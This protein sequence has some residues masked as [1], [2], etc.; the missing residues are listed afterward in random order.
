ME[1]SKKKKVKK[2]SLAQIEPPPPPSPPIATHEDEIK[3]TKK[4]KKTKKVAESSLAND[5]SPFPPISE[6]MSPSS[7]EPD[8][9][10]QA[11]KAAK[12]E[13]GKKPSLDKA[14]QPDPPPVYENKDEWEDEEETEPEK[15]LIFYEPSDSRRTKTKARPIRTRRYFSRVFFPD[16]SDKRKWRPYHELLP[17]SKSQLL[18]LITRGMT[19][20]RR[21]RLET[22]HSPFSDTYTH[23][24]MDSEEEEGSNSEYAPSTASDEEI[25]LPTHLLPF[26]PYIEKCP[27]DVTQEPPLI[28]VQKTWIDVNTIINWLQLCETQHG[29]PCIQERRTCPDNSWPGPILLIDVR[30]ECLMRPMPWEEYVALSYV[31]GQTESGRTTTENLDSLLQLGSLQG[32]KGIIPKAVQEAMELVRMLGKRYLWVDR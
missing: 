28:K 25:G 17:K 30:E 7:W 11:K 12:R 21:E 18:T 5:V 29:Y 4:S 31:W 14:K 27:E 2:S 15:P 24:S 6:L 20:Y 23:D 10:S 1:S 13:K 9:F 3:S 8:Y 22:V 26:V 16:T 19:E 32:Q